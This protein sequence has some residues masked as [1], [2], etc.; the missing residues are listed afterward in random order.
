MMSPRFETV[1]FVFFLNE[2][3]GSRVQ[4]EGVQGGGVC[5]SVGDFVC[6]VRSSGVLD[7]R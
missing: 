3:L 1:G 7:R 5:F 6:K 4:S 2:C